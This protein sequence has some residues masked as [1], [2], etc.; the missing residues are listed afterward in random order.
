MKAEAR[1][2]RWLWV[3]LLLGLLLR[4]AYAAGQ[5]TVA[6]FSGTGGDSGWYLA[7]GW[8][9]FSGQEHGWIRNIP[10]TNDSIPT[11]PVYILYAGLFQQFLAEHETVVA[12][13]L[14]Q[15][16]ASIATVYLVFR[17]GTALHCQRAGLVAAAL[18]SFHPALVFEPSNIAT[19]TLYIF[20]LSCGLWL[21]VEYFVNGLSGRSANGLSPGAAIV[22][23]AIA[24]SLAT[25]TRAVSVL[26]PLGLA[27]HMLLLRRHGYISHWRRHIALLLVVYLAV[28]STWA[29]YNLTLWDRFVFVSDRLL[30]AVWRGVESDD[31][32][33][34]QNDAL[35]LAGAEADIPEDC[36]G[37]CQYHHPAELYLARIGE[38]IGADPAGLLALRAKELAYSLLQPHGTTHLGNV[39]VRQA[40][41]DWL[42]GGR[43]LSQFSEIMH[44]EG[45]WAKL[46]TWLFHLLGIV[47]GSLGMIFLRRRW[48]LSLPV[49]G[50]AV[51]T[52]LAHSVLLALPRY[53]FAI[54]VVWLIFAGCALVIIYDR[55]RRAGATEIPAA[56]TPSAQ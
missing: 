51:Y 13:R 36:E 12:M 15:C 56:L 21:Y 38:I 53:L 25:L 20:F 8:G 31:G 19:E 55:W 27:M 7:V 32:S 14:L 43:S 46:L 44:S 11:P 5:P 17:I 49:M 42:G 10:F 22:L 34:Q 48:P 24:F 18:A 4:L 50:F 16:L 30:P 9:F 45:F 23:T 28:L 26:F 29:V 47:F 35:L 33:P 39:S 54:E 41:S 3:I 40:A 37:D 1:Y 6:S 2:S 52:V